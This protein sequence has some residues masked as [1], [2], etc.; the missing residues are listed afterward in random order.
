MRRDDMVLTMLKQKLWR[1]RR[2]KAGRH[3]YQ[4][5]CESKMVV[6]CG[7]PSLDLQLG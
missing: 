5:V 2:R 3:T 4:H 7:P 1:R 6:P